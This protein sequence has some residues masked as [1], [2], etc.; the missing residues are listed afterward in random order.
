[1][2]YSKSVF[3]ISEE[4]CRHTKSH[5]FYNKS[6]QSQINAPTAI[7][8]LRLLIQFKQ[9]TVSLLF[10]ITS[11]NYRMIKK[12]GSRQFLDTISLNRSHT[13]L[14]LFILQIVIQSIFYETELCKLIASG[15]QISSR[16]Q[17]GNAIHAIWP[18]SR[19][20]ITSRFLSNNHSVKCLGFRM[21]SCTPFFL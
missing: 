14:I 8:P 11:P 1:M 5:L 7:L 6:L 12:I 17:T 18:V 9:S 21:S 16:L 13:T 10:S 15:R 19:K 3:Y 4:L 20:Y 2:S